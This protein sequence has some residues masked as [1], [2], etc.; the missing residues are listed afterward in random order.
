M[1]G[2]IG[3]E[4]EFVCLAGWDTDA[5]VKAEY[6]LGTIRCGGW[7]GGWLPREEGRE[8]TGMRFVIC[9]DVLERANSQ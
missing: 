6:P 3:C 2:W 9:D 1:D 7:L 8:I 5:R 4:C